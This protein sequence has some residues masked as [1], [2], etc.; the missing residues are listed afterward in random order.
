MLPSRSHHFSFCHFSFRSQ[1]AFLV[2]LAMLLLTVAIFILHYGA[3]SKTQ[4]KPLRHVVLLGDTG[5]ARLEWETDGLGELL[6]RLVTEPRGRGALL[7]LSDRG[8]SEHADLAVFWSAHDGEMFFADAWT[9]GDGTVHLDSQQDYELE[10][11]QQS[12][13][14][15]SMTFRRKLDTCD[16]HDYRIDDGTTHVFFSYLNRPFSSVEEINLMD[17]PHSLRMVQ[18]AGSEIPIPHLDPSV[19]FLEII[20]PRVAVPQQETTYWC[21]V[22]HVGLTR[23]HHIVMF[24]PV[25]SRGNEHLVHHM[26]V[27]QCDPALEPPAKYSGPCDTGMKARSLRS[28]RHVLAA[29]ALGA[30]PF[31]YPED[32]GLPM[33]GPGFSPFLRLEIHYHNP[34]LLDTSL[35]SSGIRLHITPQ[36]RKYDAGVM[37]AGLVY[38]SRQAIPPGQAAFTLSGYCPSSCTSTALPTHG[39][40]VFA[41][42]LHT[43]L[44]GRKV[45]THLFRA[46]KYVQTLNADAHYNSSFQEI[47]R[48]KKE[49]HILPGDLLVTSC[50]YN[51]E[52]RDTVTLG[53]FAIS[54]EMC[55]NYMHYYPRT[56]LELCKSDPSL[57]HLH[58]FF[59]FLNKYGKEDICMCS[60][61]SVNDQYKQINWTEAKNMHLL[62]AF[63]N[64]SPIDVHCNTSFA[65]RFPVNWKALPLPNVPPTPP[66]SHN[67][68]TLDIFTSPTVDLQSVND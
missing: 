44:A 11:A 35:D 27:F 54:D 24:E 53:G 31:Y 42:Q 9:D 21:H 61:M 32:V 22:V 23:K 12:Q 37:E 34:L 50:E 4:E 2:G 1:E 58:K 51:T 8:A 49:V 68:N 36:L 19:S 38:S 18:L 45:F 63:Y 25:I 28:C 41:S 60:Q 39:I 15:F 30:K 66:P 10:S 6:M 14:Q 40:W 20:V 43:H 29:W 46:G 57:T 62:R 47:R 13:G 65:T 52:D 16:P 59:S 56:D 7:G 64:I 33:G 17:L 48:L 3:A 67:C 5:S 55:V 26:E